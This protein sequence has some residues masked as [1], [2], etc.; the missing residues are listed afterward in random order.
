MH[1]H[2]RGDEGNSHRYLRY[3]FLM[4]E[5]ESTKTCSVCL[6]TKPVEDFYRQSTKPEHPYYERRLGRCKE[7]VIKQNGDRQRKTYDPDKFRRWYLKATFGI[8]V[9]DYERMAEEQG[10]TCAI[11]DGPPGGRHGRLHVDHCHETGR[12]R[13]LLCDACNRGMGYLGDSAAH[14]T[15]AAQY[16]IGGAEHV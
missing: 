16:L 8:T 11:C 10:G 13:G 4:T 7:C 12:V 3:N 6:E 14:L 15:R 5:G 1:G 9:E 2:G